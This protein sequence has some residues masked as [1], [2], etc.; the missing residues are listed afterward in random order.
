MFKGKEYVKWVITIPPEDVEFL[1]DQMILAGMRV[2]AAAQVVR[3]V[4]HASTSLRAAVI[5]GP[6]L[7]GTFD[8]YGANGGLGR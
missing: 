3:A 6:R 1:A 7:F 2:P 8:F 4:A 5:L